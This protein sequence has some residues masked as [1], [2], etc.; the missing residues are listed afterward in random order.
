LPEPPEGKH[1]ATEIISVVPERELLHLR[2]AWPLVQQLPKPYKGK[3]HDA[4][5]DSFK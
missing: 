3:R 2:P 1:N 5:T 4:F